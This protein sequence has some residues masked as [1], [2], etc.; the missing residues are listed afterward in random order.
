[1]VGSWASKESNELVN[2]ELITYSQEWDINIRDNF[3]DLRNVETENQYLVLNDIDNNYVDINKMNETNKLINIQINELL[4][5]VKSQKKILRLVNDNFLR[6]D[7]LKQIQNLNAQISLLKANR[8]K[9]ESI[10]KN[11]KDKSDKL[12]IKNAKKNKD[13]IMKFISENYG[14]KIEFAIDTLIQSKI[15]FT[16]AINIIKSSDLD[17]VEKGIQLSQLENELISVNDALQKLGIV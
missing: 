11:I 6:N 3:R 5:S 14:S 8:A 4:N 9:N 10:L 2:F 17:N 13:E 7:I 16:E 1:M 15:Q 12:K